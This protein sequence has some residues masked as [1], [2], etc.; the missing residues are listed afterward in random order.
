MSSDE[1]EALR[2]YKISVE[3]QMIEEAGP[4]SVMMLPE[5]DYIR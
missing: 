5:M 2:A 4:A 3:Y 1:K